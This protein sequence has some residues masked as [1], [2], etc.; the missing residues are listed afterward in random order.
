MSVTAR[1]I[2]SLIITVFMIAGM[3]LILPACDIVDIVKDKVIDPYQEPVSKQ[4][5]ARL[6]IGAI[7]RKS[8]VSDS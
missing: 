6:I 8:D 2:M 4:E 5:L 7:S 1:R 3:V